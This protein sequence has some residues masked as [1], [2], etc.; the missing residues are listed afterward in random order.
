ML[1]RPKSLI[2]SITTL[3]VLSTFEFGVLS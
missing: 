3:Q 1:Q 2:T